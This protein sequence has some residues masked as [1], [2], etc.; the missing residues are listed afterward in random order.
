MRTR[1]GR[2][3]LKGGRKLADRIAEICVA[4]TR[5]LSAFSPVQLVDTTPC[6]SQRLDIKAALTLRHFT[7]GAQ[8]ARLH[9]CMRLSE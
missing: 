4:R 6:V 2:A 1:S 8:D 7:F 3:A 5:S 9:A